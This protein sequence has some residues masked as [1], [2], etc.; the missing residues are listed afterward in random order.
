[1]SKKKDKAG[2]DPN[3]WM[4][5]FSDLLTL[6]LTFFVL[7]L[8]MSSMDDM[9]LKEAFGALKGA[10]GVLEYGAGSAVN[11]DSFIT[12]RNISA[13]AKSDLLKLFKELKGVMEAEKTVDIMKVLNIEGT[14]IEVRSDSRG[15]VIALP[16]MVL[17][18][19]GRAEL[20]EEGEKLLSQISIVLRRPSNLVSVDGHTDDRPQTS[21]RFP[22]AWE[23]SMA[24]AVTVLH[25]L[26]EEEGLLPQR[27][28]ASGY[29]S[30]RPLVANDTSA[31][32]QRNR[33]VEIVLLKERTFWR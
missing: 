11:K 22:T 14:E 28:I 32:R 12:S 30:N 4:I 29:G 5:T 1:M 24:R 15:A 2:L 23:L 25:Y 31:G 6:M 16:S 13:T 27:F 10:V 9:K 21:S 33:R 17:F 19:P 8:S 18:P 7:L 3:A 20:R 26:V